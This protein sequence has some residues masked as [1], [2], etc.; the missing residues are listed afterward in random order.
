MFGLLSILSFS[1]SSKC[2]PMVLMNVKFEYS[3]LMS[4]EYLTMIAQQISWEYLMMRKIS[5]GEP[6]GLGE[7]LRKISEGDLR[8]WETTVSLMNIWYVS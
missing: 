6:E 5:E 8:G 1:L 7:Y 3:M 4:G 2:V